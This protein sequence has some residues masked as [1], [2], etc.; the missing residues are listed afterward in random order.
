MAYE[1]TLAEAAGSRH[2]RRDI[3]PYGCLIRVS[4]PGA[5]ARAVAEAVC[6]RLLEIMTLLTTSDFEQADF[7]KMRRP[8][9]GR[10][11]LATSAAFGKYEGKTHHE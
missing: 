5:V 3:C 4:H 9:C 11:R 2:H 6:R 10:S 8:V 7:D 1:L